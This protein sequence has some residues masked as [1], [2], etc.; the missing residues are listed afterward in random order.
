MDNKENTYQQL[1]SHFNKIGELENIAEI[2]YWDEATMMPEGSGEARGKSLATLSGVIHELK[3]D[4]K[5][6]DWLLESEG[7]NSLDLWQ[8]ANVFEITWRPTMKKSP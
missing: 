2:A 7:N 3:T 1:Q 5:I 8:K 4:I 6:R